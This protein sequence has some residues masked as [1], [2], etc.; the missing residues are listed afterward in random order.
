MSNVISLDK[1]RAVKA[2]SDLADA[3]AEHL[4]VSVPE[5]AEMVGDTADGVREAL[6]ECLERNLLYRAHDEKQKE[7]ER[8]LGRDPD[9]CHNYV[10]PEY[11][12]HEGEE[13]VPN[14]NNPELS[15]VEFTGRKHFCREAA[16][17]GCTHRMLEPPPS[18]PFVDVPSHN[19]CVRILQRIG[20]VRNS[21]F[22]EE[23]GTNF[24]FHK[25][26]EKLWV[27]YVLLLVETGRIT[28][29]EEELASLMESLDEAHAKYCG[30][31]ALARRYFHDRALP[32]DV[33]TISELVAQ[34]D[35]L[36]AFIR[37]ELEWPDGRCPCGGDV[38]WDGVAHTE[39]C[40]FQHRNP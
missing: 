6:V 16:A 13:L 34:R 20:Y 17:Q 30:G 22:E 15:Y 9:T 12:S 36:V 21:S 38:G 2:R 29:P 27:A 24:M 3:V 11:V 32:D 40:R 28:I 19:E 4:N 1:R 5:L 39:H 23:L 33:A 7:R 37:G 35:A 8:Q 31:N 18:D 25:N 26:T 14:E 10:C